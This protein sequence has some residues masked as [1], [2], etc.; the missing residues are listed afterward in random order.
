M[1]SEQAS[2][3]TL[4]RGQGVI[5]QGLRAESGILRAAD[6][7]STG[8]AGHVMKARNGPV[9]TGQRGRID[10]MA[11]KDHIYI[12]AFAQYVAMKSPLRRWAQ[13]DIGAVKI[14]FHQVFR[15]HR[16]VGQGGW[17]DKKTAL[18][19]HRKVSGGSLIDSAGIHTA[20]YIHHLPAQIL[21]DCC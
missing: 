15:L 8:Y 10:G 3:A 4:Q 16:L 6:R 19:A 21:H 13:T 20:A 9:V 11:V 1:L 14:H 18:R 17:R 5:G 7:C 2:E 12:R